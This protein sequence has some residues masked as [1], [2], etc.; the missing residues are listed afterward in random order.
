MKQLHLITYRALMDHYEAEGDDFLGQ[1]SID[2]ESWVH[3]FI[4]KPKRYQVASSAGRVM[5]T[6]FQDRNCVILIHLKP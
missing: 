4:T 5:L 6:V 2:D 1:N 3:H